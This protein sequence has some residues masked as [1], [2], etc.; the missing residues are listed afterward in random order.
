ML[1]LLFVLHN[2][3][4]NTLF[5]SVLSHIVY[6]LFLSVSLINWITML[7]LGDESSIIVSYGKNLIL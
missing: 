5:T 6:A 2:Q 3:T 1:P 4:L 7:I